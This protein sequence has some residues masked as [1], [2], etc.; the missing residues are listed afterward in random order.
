MKAESMFDTLNSE[1][2]QTI[3]NQLRGYAEIPYDEFIQFLGK[4]N[5]IPL[6]EHKTNYESKISVTPIVNPY[7]NVIG[8]VL[9]NLKFLT[10]NEFGR[11][12]P[13]KTYFFLKFY[14]I[15]KHLHIK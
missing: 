11:M 9:S 12:V 10:I 14:T 2:V 15:R 4:M 13:K 8:M 1:N 3:K 6:P 5:A 7:G